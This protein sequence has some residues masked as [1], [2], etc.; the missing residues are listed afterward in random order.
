MA[1]TAAKRTGPIARRILLVEDDAASSRA[2]SEMLEIEGYE[3]R[4]V[5]NGADAIDILR[6]FTP[7]A[8]VVDLQ[9][10]VMDG[11][12][13]IELYRRRVRPAASVVVM[14]GRSDGRAIAQSIGADGYVA[15]PV[16]MDVLLRT[17][18]VALAVA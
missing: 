1:L 11:R 7:D 3:V 9:L 8:V 12:S 10:P 4:A 6:V 17:I 15:K 16:E 2:I 18:S 5:A 13:F 14:S